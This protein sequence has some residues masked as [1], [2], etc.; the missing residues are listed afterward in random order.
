MT[1]I[2]YKDGVLAADRLGVAGS[3]KTQHTKVRL[4]RDKSAALAIAGCASRGKELQDWYDNG[5]EADNFPE[6]QDGHEAVLIV[7]REDGV[8]EYDGCPFPIQVEGEF[9]AWGSGAEFASMA[10]HL[11]LSASEA[12]RAT[13]DLCAFCGLGQDSIALTQL[14]F[15]PEEV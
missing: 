4:S 15:K 12:V 3:L 11:G 13:E 9:S 10:M 8:W 1:V 5:E 14:K 7:M 6:Q 2:A